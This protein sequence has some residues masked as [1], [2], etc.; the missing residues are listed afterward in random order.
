M[1]GVNAT[2]GD[3][4]KVANTAGNTTR[5]HGIAISA[6]GTR[7]YHGS[8]VFTIGASSI[9][10]TT[11][12]TGGEANQIL[13]STMFTILRNEDEIS[14]LSL[15]DPDAPSI[16]ASS[17]ETPHRARD[18]ALFDG[19]ALIVASGWGG[20]KSYVYTGTEINPATGAGET[21][22]R[23]GDATFEDIVAGD[24]KRM[25]RTVS[26]NSTGDL[27]ASAYFT[28]DDGENAAGQGGLQPSGFILV[29]VAA[30]G[31]LSLIGDFPVATYARVARFI[32]RPV[33]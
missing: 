33:E 1:W 5:Q 11:E 22:L 27:V 32:S 7:A 26:R 25:Y 15:A 9:A 6:D 13:G 14:T 31:S 19:G 10:R 20:L 17:G 3:L 21:E 8:V 30:D 16:I 2:T 4:M 29:N 28:N 18:L 24:V 12:G 23:D